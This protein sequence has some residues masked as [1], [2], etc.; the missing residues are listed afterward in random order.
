MAIVIN[1]RVWETT[2][3]TGTGDL[4]LAGAVAGYV[5][6][7]AGIGANNETFY[8]I[9]NESGEWEVGIGTLDGAG[10]TLTR[11]TVLNS[12]NAGSAVNLS[13][14]TKQVFVDIPASERFFKGGSNVP[15]EFFRA[16]S[17]QGGTNLTSGAQDL[18]WSA[19]ALTSNHYSHTAGS[20]EITINTTGNHEITFNVGITGATNRVQL[21][22]TL[23]VDTGSGF[24]EDTE[25]ST[26]DYVARDASQNSGAV[27]FSAPRAFNAGDV[28][29]VRASVSVDSGSASNIDANRTS[30]SLAYGA[31]EKGDAG[32]QGPAGSN[33]A[34]QTITFGA[35]STADLS[36][37]ENHVLTVTGNTILD[38]SNL[39]EGQ[40]GSII[41]EFSGGPHTV[42][43]AGKWIDPP[44]VPTDANQK[45][46]LVYHVRSGTEILVGLAN[47]F[48]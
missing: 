40:A 6:F 13:A 29:R 30:V 42:S 20:A 24:V 28:I 11:T 5:T 19:G 7:A 10:T 22:A 8:V 15:R 26:F 38:A 35:T 2:T 43:F 4:S 45:H 39:T 21:T 25:Y 34:F 37:S 12:S 9:D 18:T 36:A 32:P 46:W 17:D 47:S 44:S 48:T 1:D 3:T 16:T 31:G 27:T 33:Q 41:L 14:G 23:W